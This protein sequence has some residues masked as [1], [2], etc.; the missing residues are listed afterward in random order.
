[1]QSGAFLYFTTVSVCLGLALGL[2]LQ[3]GV[4][5]V[6]ALFLCGTIVLCMA[7]VVQRKEVILVAVGICACALGIIR[8][9]I[10]LSI[11]AQENLPQF[12]DQQAS[13]VGTVFD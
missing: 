5:I 4:V 12:A 13:V 8:S 1:M 9:D 6:V 7:L 2:L 11:Q 10:F 3:L